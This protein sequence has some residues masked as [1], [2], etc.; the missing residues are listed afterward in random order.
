M[1]SIPRRP[2]PTGGPVS[3][4]FRRALQRDGQRPEDSPFADV[5]YQAGQ[6][7][8]QLLIAAAIMNTQ[9][10]LS[11]SV[12]GRIQEIMRGAVEGRGDETSRALVELMLS[13]FDELERLADV[14][15]THGGSH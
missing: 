2:G 11:P 7:A 13:R 4:L 14:V 3:H 5:A 12:A 9:P 8:L 10:W 6:A 15:K 1:D